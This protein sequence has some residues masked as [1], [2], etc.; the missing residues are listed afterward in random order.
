MRRGVEAGAA[1]STIVGGRPSPFE[2]P[3]NAGSSG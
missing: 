1:A 3:A 2:T